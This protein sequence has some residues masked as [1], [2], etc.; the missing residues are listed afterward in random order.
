MSKEKI[1]VKFISPNRL[2]C[3]EYLGCNTD[4]DKIGAYLAY[5][6][7]SGYFL[8]IIQLVEVSLRNAMDVEFSG[9]YGDEWY[10]CIKFS[11][12]TSRTMLKSAMVKAKKEIKGRKVKKD[13]VI[14]RLTLGFWVYLLDK[15]YTD[16]SSEYFIWTPKI[17]DNVFQGAFQHDKKIKTKEI[18]KQLHLVLELRNRLFHHEPIWKGHN[19][20][21]HENA[22]E[23]ILKYYNFLN[24]VL[25]W[26]S[27]DI[28]NVLD[29][30]KLIKGCKIRKFK[31][32]LRYFSSKISD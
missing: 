2:L 20:K 9:I 3:Y 22:L 32:K 18:F 21:T 5:Q 19:C 28:H 31:K 26:V 25:S 12:K 8:P 27:N 29:E 24:K 6:E 30:S 7:L 23:N 13:D 17:R 16:T 4:L 11:S 15:P 10:K 1:F 14:S